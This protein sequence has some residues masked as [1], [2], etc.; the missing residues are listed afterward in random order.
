MYLVPY[1]GKAPFMQVT[2]ERAYTL[3]DEY[4]IAKSWPV[5]GDGGDHI[6]LGIVARTQRLVVVPDIP[7]LRADIHRGIGVELATLWGIPTTDLSVGLLEF[8]VRPAQ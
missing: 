2:H 6:L 7:N 5:Q 8:R 3:P 4:P 1:H